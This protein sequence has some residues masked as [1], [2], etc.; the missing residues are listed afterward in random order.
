LR[1]TRSTGAL[2]GVL[3]A[4][5]AIWAAL[6]PFVG[7]YFDY[8]FSPDTPWHVTGDRLLLDVLPGAVALLAA[9]VMLG[10]RS[11]RVGVLGGLL[12]VLA[13]AWLIL[14]PAA[15][16]MWEPRNGPIGGPLG[17]PPHRMLELA[18]YFYGLGALI[19]MLGAIT[20]GRFSARPTLFEEGV[21]DERTRVESQR[22]LRAAS[23]ADVQA[24]TASRTW[25]RLP[26]AVRS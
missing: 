13:G 25:T 2:S 15:S 11:R 6:V 20:I 8:S 26:R 1:V 14:G 5:L 12:A 7:P 10:A 19:A 18:G 9:G 23:A 17:G 16:L 21:I 22:A 3:I 24:K 4:A